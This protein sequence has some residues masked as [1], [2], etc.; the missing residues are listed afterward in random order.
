MDVIGIW[1]S[2]LLLLPGAGIAMGV[3]I[4]VQSERL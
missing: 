3:A 4:G 1:L 2:P